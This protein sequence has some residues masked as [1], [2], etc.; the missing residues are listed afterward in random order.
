ML[1][2][3]KGVWTGFPDLDR[4][5]SGFGPSELIVV[6]SRPSV[7]KTDF[8]LNIIRHVTTMQ[9]KTA[10][11]FSLESDTQAVMTR[12][13][14]AESKTHKSKINNGLLSAEEWEK[15]S[16]ATG[17]LGSVDIF[18]DDSP[19][20]TVLTMSNKLKSLY[21]P[22]DLIVIDYLG[23][24]KGDFGQNRYEVTSEIIRQLKNLA[25][26]F[27][28][29]IIITCQ[30]SREIEDRLSKRPIL[31]DLR[32]SGEIEQAADKVLFLYREDYY[33]PRTEKKNIVEVIVAKQRNGPVGTIELYYP[34][35]LGAFLTLS[36]PVF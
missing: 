36:Q 34:P 7:G 1:G 28:C 6:A 3:F 26:E 23:L 8:V 22:L 14:A 29:P 21:P 10:C 19:D 13:I 33:D 31:S 11:L 32:D 17:K 2:E 5:T 20:L 24:I 16:Q 25:K 4:L 12:L 9:E 15:V 27:N 35:Q 30:L 18:I